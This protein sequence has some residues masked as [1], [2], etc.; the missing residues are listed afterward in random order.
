MLGG[1]PVTAQ[2]AVALMAIALVVGG[3]AGALFM[4]I[5][6]IGSRYDDAP[7]L[8][9]GTISPPQAGRTFIIVSSHPVPALWFS[10]PGGALLTPTRVRLS[11]GQ[12][13]SEEIE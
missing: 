4:C 3:T 12:G 9:A 1:N 6:A 13:L 7:R 2:L 8:D 11:E 5:L 10:D